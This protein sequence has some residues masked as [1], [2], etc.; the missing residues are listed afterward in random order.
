MARKVMPFLRGT[1]VY[2][3]LRR[4]IRSPE[5]AGTRFTAGRCMRANQ[6][7]QRFRSGR[8]GRFAKPSEH[9]RCGG[10]DGL[11]IGIADEASEVLFDA[12]AVIRPYMRNRLGSLPGDRDLDTAPVCL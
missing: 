3:W 11:C 9:S 8:G 5:V 6:L 7:S 10:R 2:V 1:A 12:R 4:S